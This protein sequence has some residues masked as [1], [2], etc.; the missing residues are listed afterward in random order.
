MA[1][2]FKKLGLWFWAAVPCLITLLSII[3]YLIPKHMS[4]FGSFMPFLPMIPIFYWGLNESR[5]MPYWAVFAF[6]LVIDSVTGLPLGL[7]SL[8]GVAFLAMLHAQHKYIYKEG[9]VIQWGYF[10]LLFGMTGVA[11]WLLLFIFY[12]QMPGIKYPVI[13]WVLTVCCYP[14]F[15]QIFAVLTD[16]IARERRRIEHARR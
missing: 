16:T 7:S 13:Q 2:T 14:F 8:L 15:H 4:G 3:I 5:M 1:H 10:A 12:G 9:F 6:G 11:H